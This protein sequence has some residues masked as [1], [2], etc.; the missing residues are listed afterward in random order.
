MEKKVG[1]VLSL[2][3]NLFKKEWQFLIVAII[4]MFLIGVYDGFFGVTEEQYATSN[5]LTTI[6]AQIVSVIF[7]IGF[8]RVLVDIV[9]G[10]S[11]TYTR[12]FSA[13]SDVKM[14]V[15]YVVTTI[16]IVLITLSGFIF[17]IIPGVIAAIRASL[18]PYV[19][20]TQ[21]VGPIDAVKKSFA[22]T[23]GNFWFL[24]RVYLTCGALSILGVIALGVG[25][26]IAIPVTALMSAI[27]YVYL[28]GNYQRT[29]ESQV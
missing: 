24:F 5:I 23:K 19:L 14:I 10:Q 25:L 3:W 18:A 20:I 17:F 22:I 29:Q 21:N 26:L 7:T 15:F 27:V 9:N 2:A 4:L 1:S 28:Y 8:I 11:A 13:F 12:F 16:L 6:F